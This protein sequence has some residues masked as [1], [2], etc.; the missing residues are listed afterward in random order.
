MIYWRQ[1]LQAA[2]GVSLAAIACAQEAPS[3]E[4]TARLQ[5]P[6]QV[7]V[8][9]TVQLELQVMTTT[10]FTQPPQLPPLELPGAMVTPPSGQGAIVREQKNGVAYNGLRYT[11]VLSPTAA[12]TLQVSAV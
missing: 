3:L 12:G 9:A 4:V 5:A 11:Y 1:I 6:A 7:Q 2:V 8:G 10:W